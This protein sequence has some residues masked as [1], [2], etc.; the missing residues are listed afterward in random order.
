M[1]DRQIGR[2]E[3]FIVVNRWVALGLKGLE[4]LHQGFWLGLLDRSALH[5]VS[6]LG[7]LRLDRQP[8]DWLAV[9]DTGACGYP[10]SLNY[11]LRPR[12]AGVL[13]EGERFRLVPRPETV[14]QLAAREPG[15]P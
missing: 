7:C 12:L 6:E 13:V 4:V 2:A 10:M 3:T 1:A 14:N 9:L 8:E 11:N 5:R 15:H